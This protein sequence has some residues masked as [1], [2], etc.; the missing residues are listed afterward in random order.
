MYFNN[1]ILNVSTLIY[2]HSGLIPLDYRMVILNYRLSLFVS[3]AGI[4]RKEVV[5]YGCGAFV[6]A[7][8]TGVSSVK[9]P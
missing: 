2:T 9:C 3:L 7:G 8:V 6:D 5:G 1:N 4:A